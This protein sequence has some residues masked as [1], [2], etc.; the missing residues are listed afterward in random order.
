M[1]K[2]K[3]D[4]SKYST[5]DIHYKFE[6]DLPSNFDVKEVDEDLNVCDKCLVIV[7]WFDEMYWS[8]EECQETNDILGDYDSVCDDCYV[9]LANKIGGKK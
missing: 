3:I 2:E 5:D 8:G 4:Y 7:R 1:N 6:Y 9:D